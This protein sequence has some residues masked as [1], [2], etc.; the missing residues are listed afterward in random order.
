MTQVQLWGLPRMQRPSIVEAAPRINDKSD[1][2]VQF[3]GADPQQ[4]AESVHTDLMTEDVPIMP[5]PWTLHLW[6]VDLR[7]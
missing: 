1:V 6:A 3:R 4:S 7:T 5:G 2:F